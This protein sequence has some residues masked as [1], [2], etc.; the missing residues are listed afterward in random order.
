M[1]YFDN[2]ATTLQK[3]PEVARAVTAALSSFGGVGR[4]V[5]P[6]S[7]AAGLAVYEARDAVASLLGAPGADRVAF[8][9]N[10]TAVLNIAIRGLLPQGGVAVTTAASHNSVL[11]PLFAA[12]DERGCEVRVAPHDARGSLDYA[13]LERLVR[14]ADLVVLT[15]AS[16]LTGDV[17]DA[18]R[19]AH[20]VHEAGA[21]VILDAAQTAG[22]LPVDMAALGVDVLCFTGHKSLMGPQGTGGLCVA[23][24]TD[25][26][27]LLEGGSG[28]HSFDERHPRFMPESL[29][30]GTL[31][32]HG[33]AGLAA[34]VAYL[35]A[36]GMADVAAH[37]ACLVQRLRAGLV[38][39]PGVRVLGGGEAAGHCGIVAL[40]V[41]EA[42]SALVADRLATEW[43]ICTRAGAHCAPLMHRALG[44]E[45][46][47]AVRVSFGAFNTEEEVDACLE[48]LE[49][50]AHDVSRGR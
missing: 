18:A 5:H 34:G 21:R 29:E 39:M 25:V 3:P 24:G 12:R 23:A 28:T 11:R 16:N 10:A 33:L 41:G 27:P 47:G 32:A 31:N 30:A 20:V 15:H 36:R 26:P 48:A 37:E 1:I 17:Y 7:L 2:A 44:T 46:Q 13:A 43:G 19:V 4:G 22:A 35:Q 45:S 6:A 50:I 8:A 9:A 14:G 38:R 40:N 49:V 42:D